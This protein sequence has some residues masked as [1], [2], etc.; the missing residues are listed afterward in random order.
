MFFACLTFRFST[1]LA[2]PVLLFDEND[3]K[4]SDVWW[5]R[6]LKVV[7]HLIIDQKSKEIS[8]KF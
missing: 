7:N 8:I 2:L 4:L 5:P 6:K 3:R 1:V